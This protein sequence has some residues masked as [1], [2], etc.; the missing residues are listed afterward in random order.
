MPCLFDPAEEQGFIL[1]NTNQ[2]A[3]KMQADTPQAIPHH[4]LKSLK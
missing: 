2:P 3:L 4:Y 1:R